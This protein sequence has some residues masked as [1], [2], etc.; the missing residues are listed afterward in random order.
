[1]H[2]F[3]ANYYYYYINMYIYSQTSTPLP[4][5]NTN[6]DTV[7]RTEEYPDVVISTWQIIPYN[8][9]LYSGIWILFFQIFRRITTIELSIIYLDLSVRDNRTVLLLYW[10]ANHYYIIVKSSRPETSV[11]FIVTK[12]CDAFS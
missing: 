3:S 12:R 10:K 11:H 6:S 9:N 7:E 1:M 5:I 8:K 2:G 4:Y